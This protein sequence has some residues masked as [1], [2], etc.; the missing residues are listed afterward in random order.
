MIVTSWANLPYLDP[1]VAHDESGRAYI[2]NVYDTL[3]SMEYRGGTVVVIPWLAE[4]WEV[5]ED[6]L[7]WTFYLRKGVKFHYSGREMTADDVVFSIL[8]ETIMAEGMGYLL[9]PWVDVNKVVAID[10]YTVQ[11]TL[12]K[13][14][15]VFEYLASYIYVVDSEEVKKNIRCPGPYGEWCDFGK[16]WLMEGHRSV[17]TGPY[18]LAEYVP[19][20]HV[21][22]VKNKDWWGTF[23]PR[24][25]E[26]VKIVAIIDPVPTL[27]LMS[28]RELDIST[29]WLPP[30]T[31]EELDKIEG[32]D[33]A[34]LRLYGMYYLMM[35]TRKPPLDD[36]QVRKALFYLFDYDTFL[37][38]MPQHEKATSIVPSNMI[39]VCPFPEPVEFNI[40]KAREELMKSKYW[41]QL[42]KYP[43]DITWRAPVP[44]E[45]RVG[46][47]LATAAEQVGLKI[48]IEKLDWLFVVEA[49]TRW[50]TPN[51]I[52]PMWITADYPEAI[53]M[54]YL[55]WHSSSHGTV[56]QNE[57]F[58]EDI[59]K[60][61]DAKIED[62][63]ATLNK[64]ERLRKTCELIRYIFYL[65]PSIFAGDFIGFKAYQTYI[66]WPAARGE[67]V[68]VFGWDVEYWKMNLNLEEKARLL[69]MK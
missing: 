50:D 45:D 6:G 40:E 3:L 31:Y 64:E 52:E 21:L 25:P 36:I 12:K 17:G 30:E 47:L 11:V 56:N 37:K 44:G 26:K 7:V 28:K 27:T 10:R 23:A 62:V 57:W 59:Q 46:Y 43:M 66:E 5:T 34:R 39:G 4:R 63:L 19:G 35:N 14:C 9:V 41:G 15:G 24:A 53:S 48:N 18:M 20:S 16:G 51:E 1:H 49:M 29:I 38:L 2:H 13:P 58:T 60:E 42:D 55:R 65:Y 69:G 54:I 33:V 22:I 32:I 68:G 67:M 61:L 8:R